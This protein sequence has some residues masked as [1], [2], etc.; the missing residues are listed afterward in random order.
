[1]QTQG[2][3]SLKVAD[4]ETALR[5]EPLQPGHWPALASLFG[6]KGAC[7]GCW[8]MLWRAEYGGARF[9]ADK[10]EAN[11]T[12]FA[13][14]V[15]ANRVHGCIAFRAEQPIGWLSV[16]RK[17]EFPYFQRSRSLASATLPGTWAVTCFFIRPSERGVGVATALLKA[18]VEY[19]AAAG[20]AALE[21][22]PVAPRSARIPAAFAWTG[23]PALFLSAGFESGCDAQSGRLVYRYTYARHRTQASPGTT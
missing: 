4:A 10:G 8:C 6:A 20:A 21:G 11:R 15:A 17:E 23:V 12:R 18:A 1:M 7:G 3:S 13:A 19:A 22:Y 2:P 9:D 14:L 5:I 16:G